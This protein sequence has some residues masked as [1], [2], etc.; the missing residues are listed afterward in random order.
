MIQ[1]TVTYSN[2]HFKSLSIKGHGNAG[3]GNDLVCAGVSSC[4]IGSLNALKDLNNFEI[5]VK[6]GN[7]KIIAKSNCSTH[8][9]VV[10]ETLIVQIQTIS[11]RY[12]EECKVSEKEG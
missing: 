2:S 4:F 10:M 11:N 3:Y 8:D 9:E 1:V 7:S 12:P 5:D 6:A